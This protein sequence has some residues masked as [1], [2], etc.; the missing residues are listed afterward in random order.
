MK[1]RIG[2]HAFLSVL[3]TY[4]DRYYAALELVSAQ[5]TAIGA[6]IAALAAVAGDSLAVRNTGTANP[7]KLL[8]AWA[9]VQVAGTAR[10]RSPKF[11]DNVQ[12]IR[13]DTIISDPTPFL[14]RGLS[15]NV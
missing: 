6:T 7:A 15:Q 4:Q 14:P 12:G 11:H 10:I 3:A 5:G 13:V 1:T 9:D 8:K 2:N